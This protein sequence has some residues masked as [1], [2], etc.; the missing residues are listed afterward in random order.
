MRE[1]SRAQANLEVIAEDGRWVDGFG[2]GDID[3]ADCDGYTARGHGRGRTCHRRQGGVEGKDVY[4]V[5]DGHGVA[6]RVDG[7][8]HP[9]GR[10]TRGHFGADGELAA[11]RRPGK[12][13]FFEVKGFVADNDLDSDGGIGIDARMLVEETEGQGH[14]LADTQLGAAQVER[15]RSDDGRDGINDKVLRAAPLRSLEAIVDGLHGPEVGAAGEVLQTMLEI[16][17]GITRAVR[18]IAGEHLV[19][20]G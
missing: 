16:L 7:T 3:L 14:G 13:Q 5:E 19:A 9:Q 10:R 6:L 11:P 15:G 17:A 12:L 8:H 1:W 18:D 20:F 4:G 2:K